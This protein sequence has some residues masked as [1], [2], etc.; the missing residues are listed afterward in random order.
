MRT[1]HDRLMGD[2]QV[3]GFPLRFSNFPDE[4]DLDAP[5]LGEHN[6]RVLSDYLGYAPGEIERLARSGVLF[7][8][9]T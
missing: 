2:F 4:L 8:K 7:S 5:L 1:I 3:P 9:P 6:A